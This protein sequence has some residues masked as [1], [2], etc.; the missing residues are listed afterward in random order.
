MNKLR[1]QTYVVIFG[2]S[3]KAGK[4][5]DLLLI[6]IILASV[7]LI[8]LDSVQSI[9]QAVGTSFYIAELIFTF[10]FTIEYI[11]RIWCHP[12]PWRYVRSFYGI[13]DLISILPTYFGFFVTHANYLV[14]IRILRVLRIFRILRLMRYLSEANILMR[15]LWLS[16]RKIFIFFS[17]VMAITTIFGSLM[18]IIEGPEN[19]FSSIPKSIYWAIVTIT[20]VGYGDISP[21]TVLGQTIAS[22]AMILGYSIIAVPTGIITA[23][24]ASEMQRDKSERK[25]HRCSRSGHDN[26][27]IHCKF[28]G[29][30]LFPQKGTFQ[31]SSA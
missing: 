1:L 28:C 18:Y 15:S 12:H 19:G 26:D 17:L 29:A 24:L 11:V 31:E 22:L 27:A 9:Q 14:V 13:V 23:E 3:T 7:F 21:Q 2:T 16:R 4:R 10:L 25:C 20:T 8:A 6:Y 5:F 30:D